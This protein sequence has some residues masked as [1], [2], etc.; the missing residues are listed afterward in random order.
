MLLD[1]LRS[2]SVSVVVRAATFI[3][4]G[5]KWFR[6]WPCAV[7]VVPKP[8]VLLTPPLIVILC[9]SLCGT[10]HLL[11]QREVGIN[12]MSAVS[13]GKNVHKHHSIWPS[14]MY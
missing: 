8:R 12:S 5:S 10:L 11:Q 14:G 1:T 3:N 13:E 7:M 9:A 2:T 4:T 6:P